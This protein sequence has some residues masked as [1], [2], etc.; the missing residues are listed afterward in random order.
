MNFNEW[1]GTFIPDNLATQ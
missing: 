1:I